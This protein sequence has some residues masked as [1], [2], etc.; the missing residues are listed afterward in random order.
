LPLAIETE[1]ESDIR[2][3][4]ALAARLKLR[5]VLV[6]AAEG[7]RAADAIAAAHVPVVLNPFANLPTSFDE[8]GSRLDNAA[9]LAAHGVTVAIGKAGGGIEESYNAGLALR[10]GA[11]LAVANGLPHATG[12]A[13]IITAPRAIWG[14]PAPTLTAGAP[15][16]IVVWDGD[17]LEPATNARAVIIEGQEANL[18]NRQRALAEHYLGGERR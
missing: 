12:L 16:D 4:L 15:A 13:A 18:A 8:L 9:I 14:L 7:W 5:L 1:R 6:G 17:P 11:G 10:E 3:A 2:T